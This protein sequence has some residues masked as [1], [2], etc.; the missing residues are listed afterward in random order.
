MSAW[1]AEIYAAAGEEF[2]IN[3]NPQLR[4]ILFEKLQLPT[5]KR[6]STG[7]STNASVLQELAESGHTLPQLLLEYRELF[8][9]EGTYLDALPALLLPTDGRLHTS[10]NQTVASTGRLSS[11]DPNS[12]ESG[13]VIRRELPHWLN[14]P[15]IRPLILGAAHPHALNP[16]SVRLILRRIR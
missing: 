5:R 6:T 11:S 1:S 9:L 4:T 8:E 14:L 3:S 13:G 2:N 7:F 15:E 12:G 16:G 10:F